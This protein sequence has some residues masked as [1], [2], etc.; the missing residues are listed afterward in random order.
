MKKIFCLRCNNEMKFSG[1]RKIQ[2]GET[3]W[4]LGDI[5]NLIAGAMEVN[6]YS[7][8]DCGKIE[9]FHADETDGEIAKIICPECGKKHDCDY[10][11]CPF[12]GYRY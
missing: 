5:P 4:V 8:P 9:F 6:I 11:K 3:G 1:T 10:P 7:C 12:C 2:L